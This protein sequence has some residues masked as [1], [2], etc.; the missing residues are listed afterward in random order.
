M[1]I[2]S[3][4]NVVGYKDL[5]NGFCTE[6]SENMNYIIGANFQRKSTIGSLFNW[7][8]TGT[9]LYGNEREQVAND[10]IKVHNIIVDITF[11]DNYGIEHRLIRDKGKQMN[12]ILDGKEVKQEMLAQFYHDKDVFLVSH[13]PYYF[14]S[15]E[16]KEQKD[17]LRKILPSIYPEQTFKF[18]T[19]D[20]Q[21]IIGKPIECLGSYTDKK[22]AEISELNKEYEQNCG[23]LE[24]YKTMAL[25]QVE[26]LLLFDK[27]ELLQELQA[28]YDM[29]ASDIGNS[30]LEDIQRSIT[31]INERLAEIFKDKLVN[32]TENYNKENSKLKNIDAE[33]SICA[34]CRQEI[35]DNETKE[36][37]KKFYQ[38]EL[39]KL[40]EKADKLK[41]DAMQLVEERKKKQ[42]ILNKLETPDT[43]QLEIEKQELKSK[44]EELQEEKKNILVHNNGVKTKQEQ[45]KQA[46]DKILLLEK[47]Q[48]EILDML[49][50]CKKQRKIAN[51]LKILV[52]ERQQEEI[53]KFLNKVDIQFSKINKIDDKIVECCEILYEGRE[54]KKLSKSQ[55]IR[56]C[57]EISNV[58]NNLSGLKAPIFFDD[59]ES[60]TDIAK[61]ENTQMIISLVIKYNPLEILYDYEDVLDR[62]K[63]S[64][65]REIE[66][67]SSFIIEQ[68]A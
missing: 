59:A 49:E 55:Q 52:I 2:K 46:K 6:F 8:L 13:N 22:N 43:K 1:Y 58:F 62:K 10:K 41:E 30:N 7:C 16:P 15:L 48:Q 64:V 28:K 50:K 63:K 4:N 36:H 66:E 24:A 38:K 40:Q 18:L 47:A 33:K 27:E 11:I 19:E 12:L 14:P 42:E 37:L 60:T 51:K 53:N 35:K 45:V 67:S 39:N 20:E 21:K 3:I 68:A 25:N 31:R 54:Y 17:L 23:S 34:S 44:I 32:I 9:S 26:E 61:I 65:E 56:T 57:L 5:P 29:I